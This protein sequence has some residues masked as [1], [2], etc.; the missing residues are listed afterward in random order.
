[1]E[2]RSSRPSTCQ[3]ESTRPPDNLSE[4]LMPLKASK[5]CQ[6]DGSTLP[7]ANI[8]KSWLARRSLPWMAIALLGF[9]GA[10]SLDPKTL[11]LQPREILVFLLAGFNL[12]LIGIWLLLARQI[13][14]KNQTIDRLIQ[15]CQDASQ[16][17]ARCSQAEDNQ[18]HQTLTVQDLYNNAPCGYHSIGVDGTVLLMNDTELEMLG[19]SREEVVGKKIFLDF[20]APE[21]QQKWIEKFQQLKT[22]GVVK[23][24]EILLKSRNGE[25]FPVLAN[26]TAVMDEV[27]NYVMSRSTLVDVRKRKIIELALQKSEAQYRGIVED[28]TDLICRFLPDGRL[29]FV[30]QAYCVY[31]G[32]TADELLGK[33]FSPLIPEDDRAIV[34]EQFL[35][36]SVDCPVVQYEHRVILSN[37]EIRWQSWSDR[38][39]FD[40][41]GQ[42]VEYQGVGRDISDRKL[43]EAAVVK[44]SKALEI[45]VVGMVEVNPQGRVIHVNQ[46]YAEMNGYDETELIGDE[47]WQLIVPEDRARALRAY[48]L[49]MST[50]RAEVEVCAMRKDG[51]TFDRKIVLVK[52]YGE[53][54]QFV[55]H[56]CFTQDISSQ[57]EVDRLKDEFVSIV[58]H[59]LRTPL[60]SIAGALDLV[61]SGVLQT[62]PEQAHRM[63]AIAAQNTERLVRMINDILDM[64]RIKSGKITM[65]R[66]V[67]DLS[68]ILQESVDVMQMLADSALVKLKL[69]TPKVMV[70]VD[71]DRMIQVL[72][73]LLSNAIKF[74]ET[75]TDIE[76]EATVLNPESSSH[77]V[78]FQLDQPA[79]LVAIRDR[80]RGI[81][82]DKLSTIFEPFKQVDA[83]DSRQKGGTGL[84]LAICRSIL[85]QHHAPLW[86]ESTVGQGSTFYFA[87]PTL[88]NSS[89]T[90]V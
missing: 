63:V 41:L 81:P 18:I 25:L 79:V 14:Q 88:L 35:S 3:P 84:G 51:T 32:L 42:V 89:T 83:S 45:A 33:S 5:T 86:V 71:R 53:Q 87:L 12:G 57:R 36:L 43:Q 23:E 78:V 21:S 37:G 39:I 10:F 24:V 70:S 19:Y 48:Q 34:T 4:S 73:N 80:G 6:T 67:C 26:S 82:H 8:E 49:M 29:T 40:D 69:D 66:Q 28:Q 59:E 55:G 75:H 13:Q 31:F 90:P 52:A 77:P 47:W 74:S 11:S 38:A 62:R 68:L 58:S 20:V 56:Y 46:A 76:I 1:M 22:K 7:I 50:D 9:V 65:E 61:S 44:L 85:Q 60:T 64:E 15:S 2:N 17:V 16:Q 72:T 30:N 54:Q 27:G